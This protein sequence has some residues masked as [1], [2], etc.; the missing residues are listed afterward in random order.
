MTNLKRAGEVLPLIL[1]FK[2]CIFEETEESG[3][4]RISDK[5]LNGSLK[6]LILSKVSEIDDYT[7]DFTKG[8]ITVTKSFLIFPLSLKLHR[9]GLIWNKNDYKFIAKHK[10]ANLFGV[11]QFFG[12]LPSFISATKEQIEIDLNKIEGFEKLKNEGLFGVDLIKTTHITFLSC[13]NGYIT[14]S[15]S[16]I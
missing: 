5:L 10:L 13:E 6:K 16:F 8:E 7:C 11:V 2:D 9:F 4:I 14:F 12:V 3:K 15:Y 1:E